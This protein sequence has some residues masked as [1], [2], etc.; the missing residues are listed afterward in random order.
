MK[1]FITIN[2]KTNLFDVAVGFEV[3]LKVDE[4]YKIPRFLVSLTEDSAA[5]VFISEE[6][7]EIITPHLVSSVRVYSESIQKDPSKWYVVPQPRR[8]TL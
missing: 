8:T 1:E 7:N 3:S 5:H 2:R 6:V 4:E